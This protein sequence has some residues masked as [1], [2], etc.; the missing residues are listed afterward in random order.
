MLFEAHYARFARVDRMPPDTRTQ[1]HKEVLQS[2]SKQADVI[3]LQEC[4][5][6]DKQFQ[7]WCSSHHFVRATTRDRETSAIAFRNT[8]QMESPPK[9]EHFTD[10]R[11]GKKIPKCV[12]AAFLRTA[13]GNRFVAASCHLPWAPDLGAST[14]V[15][16]ELVS[17]VDG[18]SN[19]APVVVGGDFNIDK[20][21]QPAFEP[22][23]ARGFVDVSDIDAP[24]VISARG[25][26]DKIDFVFVRHGRGACSQVLPRDPYSLIRH[27]PLVREHEDRFEDPR[28]LR[29]APFA[30][31]PSD[32][33]ALSC[34][35]HLDFAE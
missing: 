25:T 29:A 24:T 9:M 15:V 12:V 10:A 26:F 33:A 35:V 27:V 8:L 31:F 16:E 11:T 13:E 32:H 3:F 14:S 28:G 18:W 34:D 2:L 23:R 19:G 6:H 1:L 22:L 7:D 30:D 4:H 5:L 21:D 20:S 17:I